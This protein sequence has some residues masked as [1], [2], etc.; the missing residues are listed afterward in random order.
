MHHFGDLDAQW[1]ELYLGFQVLEG[2]TA[3]ATTVF[4]NIVKSGV[5]V[6]CFVV[7]ERDSFSLSIDTRPS[8]KLSAAACAAFSLGPLELI[9]TDELLEVSLIREAMAM[10]ICTIR[11]SKIQVIY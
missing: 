9:A 11:I 2:L 3:A 8:R 6:G 7:V 1:I 4:A 5:G 10:E